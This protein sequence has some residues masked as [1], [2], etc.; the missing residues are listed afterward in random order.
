MFRFAGSE[1]TIRICPVVCQPQIVC[2]GIVDRGEEV[3]AVR[4][5]ERER[6]HYEVHEIPYGKVHSWCPERVRFECDCGEML[7]WTVPVSLC[8]CGASYT[9]I[10]SREPEERRA[11]GEAHRQWLEEYGEWREA[12]L[13]NDLR[14]EYFTFV[15]AEGSD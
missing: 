12:T 15:K 7:A 13:A 9:D 1:A 8:R 11:K 14:H 2:E 10:P 5:I 3:F 4:A 6:G